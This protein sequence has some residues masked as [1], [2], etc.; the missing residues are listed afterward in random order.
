MILKHQNNASMIFRYLIAPFSL[1]SAIAAPLDDRITAFKAA[2]TQTETAVGE[3]LELGLTEHRSALAFAAVKPWLAANAAES[4]KLLFASAQS[5]ELAGEWRQAV[6]FYRKLLK[7]KNLDAA[8][9]GAAA[10][11]CYRLLI[12]HLG[13]TESAYLFMREEGMRLR[14]FG[15]TRKFDSW[16]LAKADERKDLTAIAQWLTIIHQS[17]EPR[18]AYE[19]VLTKLLD[20]L[21]TF[22]YKQPELFMELK[23]LAAAKHTTPI[24]KAKLEWVMAVV[25]FSTKMAEALGAKRPIADS[26]MDAPLLAAKQLIAVDP[27]KG[28]IVVARGWM[29]FNAGD[30]GFFATFTNPRRA[31][32]AAPLLAVLRTLPI[33][34]AR[35]LVHLQVAAAKNRMIVPYLIS[36][37]EFKALTTER[38][39]LATAPTPVKSGK[40]T[41]AVDPSLANSRELLAL[42]ANAD[43]VAVE[44]AFQSV[45]ERV[46]KAPAGSSVLAVGAVAKLPTWSDANR[47]SIHSLFT[48][49]APLGSYP[50]KNGYEALALRV[51]NEASTATSTSHLQA[52][53][54]GLWAAAVASDDVRIFSAADAYAKLAGKSLTDGNPSL[55]M[56]FARSATQSIASRNV[57]E[58]KLQEILASLRKTAGTAAAA[59]GAVEIPVDPTDPA[60]PIY[61]SNSEFVLGNLDS[62]WQ[63]YLAHADRLVPVLRSLSVEY[64]FW[65]LQRNIEENRDQDAENLIKELT[66]WSRQ[67]EGTFSLEQDGRLKIAYA[68]L[69]FRK[70][71][72]PT[73]RAWY[74][75]IAEAAEYAGSEMQLI[76]ALGSIKVDRVS[77]NFGAAMTELDN[78]M[79]LKEPEF[80]KQ[81]RYARAEVLM[82]QESYAE[83]LEEIEQVLRQDP[84][85]ADALILRGK[86]HYEMRKLVE[87]SEIELGPSQDKTLIVPG[88][89]VKINLRDPTLNVSGVGADIEVEIWAKSGDRE[90]VLLYQLGDS[91]EKFRAEVPTA[92]GAPTP[93]DKVLQILG[94]D[95]IRFG[96][97][98]RF[99]AKMKDLPADPTVV[100][101]VASDAR[102]SFSAGA[103]PAREGERRLDIEE[104]GLSTAQATLGT[105]AV[106]PGNPVYVRVTDPDQSRTSGIDEIAVNVQTSSGDLIR[107]LMLKETSPYSG[108]FEGVIPTAGAQ[109]L[110]FASESAPGRDPNMTISAKDYPGWQGN[111]GDAEKARTFGM[112]LNDNVPLDKM[113]IDLGE[114][115]QQITRFVL[116]TSLNGKD[117]TTHARY[118]EDTP[119]WDGK[120]ILT[121]FPTFGTNSIAVSKPLGREL[122]ADWLEI[123]EYSSNRK[124]ITYLSAYVKSLSAGSLPV[125]MP[126][127]PGYGALIRYRALFHQPAAAIRRFQL[128][129]FPNDGNTI[130]LLN[131]TPAAEG[132]DNPL[133]IERELPPGLHEIQFWRADARGPLTQA[134]P[135]LLCD[136][137]GKEDLIPCPDSMFDPS[138][139]PADVKAL[140][141]QVAEILAKSTGPME[142]RFGDHTNARLVRLVIHGFDG[143][144]PA[145]RKVTLTNRAGKSLL[146]VAQDYMT[147]RE[148][149]QLEVLP[150]DTITAR[151]ED[152][153]SV[154]P[155]RNRHEQRLTVAFN[156][157]VIT[158]SF[159]NYI[160]TDE[161][162]EL[163]LE[164]IRRFRYD[165]AVAIVID[166][167]D[168]DSS[169]EKDVIEFK[170]VSSS[171]G[172]AIIKALETE[173]HSGRFLGRIFPVT[174]EPARASEIK[175]AE[176]GTLTASYLDTENLIPGIPTERSVLI[177]HARYVT[178]ALAAYQM[179]SNLLEK[180]SA[181]AVGAKQ[182]VVLPRRSLDY[183][184]AD[185]SVKSLSALVGA[186][187]RFDVIVPHLALAGSSEI[188]AYVQTDA[189]RKAM[190][191]GAKS[192]FD[193]AA[194]GTLKLKGTLTKSM[195]S[196]PS[197]YQIGKNPISPTNAPPLE[198]GRF[199]FS[200]PLILG[201]LPERS[202]ATKAAEALS[203]SALPD[204]LAVRVG[205]IVHIGYPYKDEKNQV[206][207]KV[208]DCK[209]ESHAFLDVMQ[210][211]F[212]ESLTKAFVG[213]KVYLRLIDRGLDRSADRDVA[214]VSLEASSGVKTDYELQETE[215]HSGIFKGVFTLSY[216]EEKV[217]EKLPPVAL[218]GFPVRYGDEVKVSYAAD[219]STKP[220][221]ITVNMGA[222]G[223]IEPFSKRYTGDE[224]AVKTS[225]T[226]AECFFEL[227]KKHREMEQE[228]LARREMAQARKLLAEA[229]ATHRD[230]EMRA[231]AEYLLGNLS[232]EYA[233]LAKND[234]AKLPMYQD[235]LARFS[236]IPSDYPE[237]EFA[238]KAQFKTALV[239]EK[240]GET[241]NAVEEY[242]K[243]AYKYPD[244]ELIPS[245]MSRLGGYF[246]EKGLA[247]KKQ[248]DPL[249]KNEDDASKS[250][251]LRLDQLSY[252]EFLNAAMVFAKL[253]QRFPEDPLAGLAGLRA[254]QNYMRA[255][256]YQ[257]AIKAFAITYEN[258][259]YDDREIRSQAIYWAG[260]SHERLAATYSD[261]NYRGKGEAI[262]SAYQ[263]YRRVTYDFPDSI[264]AKYARGRLADPVFAKIIEVEAEQRQ[265]MIDALKDSRKR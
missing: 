27:F 209:V 58:P 21:E 7:L 127:H 183:D 243:L 161:G 168:M 256:Q 18:D 255:L 42:P 137:S 176:G 265:Q 261:G 61:K 205:D 78:L 73:S 248:A 9:A 245:V 30:S 6:S 263:L 70:G 129:G 157:A 44:G 136:E 225:F 2:P 146:P 215:S 165:D 228:S 188:N 231:H 51:I 80:R 110:A 187:L 109:A 95:E 236:K 130:F 230:D 149:T 204:G 100:I 64:P 82:D 107:Q 195:I 103:F 189:G 258:E 62:A 108:E 254:A 211:G 97:S 178:P 102:L 17:D 227:A 11:R 177:E 48:E 252:P 52:L 121:S 59:I 85:H 251:V 49:L 234:E 66:I 16:F 179:S 5:A 84:K 101:G 31:D 172:S 41:I 133:L 140:V 119:I 113:T 216:A 259:S 29:N 56:T 233:D 81:V 193:V 158:A 206:Q 74:R 53:A 167:A 94:E 166:D 200:I 223:F 197:G 184:H 28:S 47:Q 170:V 111:V 96:Y 242:V 175:V 169:A 218:N 145:I 79:K 71:A 219:S 87:A 264:W 40:A 63:L 126:S 181:P 57:K 72:L 35:A 154:T 91:K 122:P 196:A 147:L 174:G 250:E 246:Q 214:K 33:E 77:K 123:M 39:E 34:D 10:P 260:L 4:A 38:P 162:R 212:Q 88:E 116:Q 104:L 194:P 15:N 235:A 114:K 26:M 86:I 54:P 253:Q 190:K 55:A 220:Q 171:G 143:V 106:R 3:I 160:T 1:A 191:D 208:L 239:Y 198:E 14:A 69:A 132:D 232:Q 148:N 186:S 138:S 75:K 180:T 199:S 192:P 163:I 226:L 164:P 151:F 152:K 90:R 156:D 43:P 125:V 32:K 210:N 50:N 202:F 237:T 45:I 185:A 241:E 262:N 150:G 182:E 153:S 207:W 8:T 60:Y 124:S 20:D 89:A 13:D 144:A 23:A 128:N 240:M 76:A 203:D 112:D 224:M 118:P 83:A 37:E 201:D 173:E 221:A 244:N 22:T 67:A 68:D 24:V 222:N 141:P 247:F 12:N 120:P 25:P 134:K 92:L 229:I 65:L 36:N 46:A 131:G 155:K 19:G 142:V 159:L 93:G 213:E 257:K 135:V 249:R 98:E 139:F 117:W 238:S 99:R 105:R 217:T 115:G